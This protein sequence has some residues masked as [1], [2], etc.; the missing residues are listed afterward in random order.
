MKTAIKVKATTKKGQNLLATAKNNQ[1]MFLDDVYGKH[2]AEK[3]HAWL[4]CFYKCSAEHGKNFHICSH[5][6][7]NFSV[8]WEVE[9]GY[10]LI[11]AKSNYYIVEC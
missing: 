9:N 6:S 11:T 3:H 10:R 8:A 2:S 1:G 7:F 4:D 5:N